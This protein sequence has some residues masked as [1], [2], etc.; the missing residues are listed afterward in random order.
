VGQT[1]ILLIQKN[2]KTKNMESKA[3]FKPW[4][5]PYFFQPQI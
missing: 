2:K 5:N 4:K 3:K 1:A